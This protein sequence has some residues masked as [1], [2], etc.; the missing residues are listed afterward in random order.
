LENGSQAKPMAEVARTDALEVAQ[1]ESLFL[2][3]CLFLF[4]IRE[5]FLTVETLS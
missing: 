5:P 2:F 4:E 3:L 1:G